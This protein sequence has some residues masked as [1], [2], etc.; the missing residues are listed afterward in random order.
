MSD[1]EASEH[2]NMAEHGIEGDKEQK[3]EGDINKEISKLRYFLE[4][5]DQTIES[6]DYG[7]M[8]NVNNRAGKL[9]NKISELISTTEELK[10]DNGKTPRSVRQWR[11]EIKA[12]YSTLIEEKGKLVRKLKEKQENEARETELQRLEL[13]EKQSRQKEQRRAELREAQER[14]ERHLWQEKHEAELLMSQKKL[15]M[16]KAARS[17]ATKLSFK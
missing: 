6:N 3:L 8:E 9:I 1:E 2:L 11:E 12:K 13:Q 14:H 7:E 10:I 5:T 17:S 15:E 16:E 4:E